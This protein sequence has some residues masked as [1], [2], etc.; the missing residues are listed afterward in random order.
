MKNKKTAHLLALIIMFSWGLSYLS[1]EIIVKEIDPMLS[2]LYRFFI[3]SVILYILM[4]TKYKTEKILKEDRIYLIL[5]GLT[6]I[7]L[8]F[9]FENNAVKFT[10]GSN[11]AVLISS[12]PVFTLI[13]ER[14]L[15]KERLTK[16]KIL[17]SLLS[18]IGIIII[19]AS[20]NRISLFSE[21]TFGDILALCAALTWVIYNI[22]VKKMKGIY[23][24]I[25][26]TTYQ[27]IYGTIFLIPSIFFVKPSMPSKI[28][29]INIIFL[30]VLCSVIAYIL[31]V[32]CLK[33]LG[34]TI[35][36]TYINLQP[37]ISL[38]ASAL[39]LKESIS[40]YQILGCSIIIMGISFV[41][42]GD[43]VYYKFKKRS[44]LN[45]QPMIED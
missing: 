18:I 17:G 37:A 10:S 39:I 14:I 16:S 12:I 35:I 24:S 44:L 26:I 11:V 21:G 6:G 27:S 20:K 32:Y 22:I 40:I 33:V 30:S 38:F 1:I 43:K 8:Y 5:G 3:A 41:S 34:A 2:A 31:Y 9:L 7:S 36:N 45:A 42:F 15:F 25:T 4:K 28:V 19:I 13:S 29:F 23:K